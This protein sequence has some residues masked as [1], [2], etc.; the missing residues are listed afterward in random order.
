M[1]DEERMSQRL[2]DLLE[3]FD[4]DMIH[5]ADLEGTSIPSPEYT[6]MVDKENIVSRKI[7]AWIDDAIVLGCLKSCLSKLTP[8]VGPITD[9]KE[10]HVDLMKVSIDDRKQRAREQKK[11]NKHLPDWAQPDPIATKDEE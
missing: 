6:A 9:W 7:D 2:N 1:T 11:K 8:P 4:R 10:N 3:E 5:A